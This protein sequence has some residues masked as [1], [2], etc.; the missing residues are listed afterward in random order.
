MIESNYIGQLNIGGLAVLIRGQSDKTRSN[1]LEAGSVVQIVGKEH[2]EYDVADM[3][4]VIDVNGNHF[5]KR[6][7]D[8]YLRSTKEFLRDFRRSVVIFAFFLLLLCFSIAFFIRY[9]ATPS[10]SI[11][12]SICICILV[13]V[14]IAN[15]AGRLPDDFIFFKEYILFHR[16]G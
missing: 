12:F 14:L 10:L 15:L 4:T 3:F 1:Y 9:Q 2:L 7:E 5:E 13:F 16:K 8:F 6:I 11:F